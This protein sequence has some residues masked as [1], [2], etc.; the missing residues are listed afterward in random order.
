ML[1]WVLAWLHDTVIVL[2]YFYLFFN[3]GLFCS[4][5]EGFRVWCVLFGLLYFCFLVVY[6]VLIVAV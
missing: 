4:N 3:V 2:V 6:V 5:S 1:A